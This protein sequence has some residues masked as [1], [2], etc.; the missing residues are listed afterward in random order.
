VSINDEPEPVYR[1]TPFPRGSFKAGEE[2]SAGVPVFAAVARTTTTFEKS[3]SPGFV[4]EMVSWASP[5]VTPAPVAAAGERLSIVSVLAFESEP[6]WVFVP[7]QPVTRG[8]RLYS[9]PGGAG[10]AAWVFGV[11]CILN[12][13]WVVETGIGVPPEKLSVFEVGFEMAVKYVVAPSLLVILTS[14]R[15]SYGVPA[16]ASET[17]RAVTESVPEFVWKVKAPASRMPDSGA[18]VADAGSVPEPRV[19]VGGV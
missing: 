8:E 1:T 17:V 15:P 13:V 5:A 2:P 4:Q 11:T 9:A 12:W 10:I 19:V 14:E 7:V 16:A 18:T 3:A 6:A